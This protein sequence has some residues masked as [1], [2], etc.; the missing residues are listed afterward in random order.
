MLADLVVPGS[1]PCLQELAQHYSRK[2]GQW[3]RSAAELLEQLRNCGFEMSTG[4]EE[5]LGASRS[6]NK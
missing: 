6:E 2:W 5:T 3:F 1:L 4:N